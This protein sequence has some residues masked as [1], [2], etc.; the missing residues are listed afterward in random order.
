ME[1]QTQ[2]SLLARCCHALWQGFRCLPIILVTGL[3]GLILVCIGGIRMLISGNRDGFELFFP[4][5]ATVILTGYMAFL[6][7]NLPPR[8]QVA[9]VA[10]PGEGLVN[11]PIVIPIPVAGT[12]MVLEVTLRADVAVT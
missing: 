8:G 2:P 6:R 9:P 3:V 12:N 10:Q 4:G 11:Q 1:G 7:Y 5:L